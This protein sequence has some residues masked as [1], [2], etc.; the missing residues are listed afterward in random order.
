MKCVGFSSRTPECLP[1]FVYRNVI[2]IFR[3][4][5]ERSVKRVTTWFSVV[6]AL[7]SLVASPTAGAATVSPVPPLPSPATVLTLS[8]VPDY[9]NSALQGAVCRS[10]NV[11]VPVNFFPFDTS[12]GVAA[13]DTAIDTTSGTTVVFGY[14]HGAQVASHWLAE[15]ANDVDAPSSD[16]LSFVLMGNAN[17][18]YGLQQE[19]MRSG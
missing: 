8:P 1:V 16:V 7:L 10:P 18:A 14:S 19:P 4:T 9:I 6:A 2:R 17:R 15:H 12:G 3:T 13:L 5:K 11:C